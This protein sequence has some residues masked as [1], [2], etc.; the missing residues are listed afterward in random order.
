VNG[1]PT[2][3][4]TFLMRYSEIPTLAIVVTLAGY[5]VYSTV[6]PAIVPKSIFAPS[7]VFHMKKNDLSN[8]R[9]C[10]GKRRM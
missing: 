1:S 9:R 2:Y 5:C 7:E 3:R 10:F 6:V 8:G 4:T